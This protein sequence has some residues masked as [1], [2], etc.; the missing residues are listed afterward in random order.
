MSYKTQFFLRVNCTTIFY[1]T[2]FANMPILSHIAHCYRQLVTG[3]AIWSGMRT[4]EFIPDQKL[5]RTNFY[6]FTD[7]TPRIVD[8]LVSTARY[9][10]WQSRVPSKRVI[11]S[12]KAPLFAIS[13]PQQKT[14]DLSNLKNPLKFQIVIRLLELPFSG[15]FNRNSSIKMDKDGKVMIKKFPTMLKFTEVPFILPWVVGGRNNLLVDEK[16]E[17][18][19]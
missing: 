1:L 11:G 15:K 14:A 6:D 8:F 10:S 7:S 12:D 17:K 2:K 3:H 18:S 9:E 16:S 5:I 4:P 19:E 13:I